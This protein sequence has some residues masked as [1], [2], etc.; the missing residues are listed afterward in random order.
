MRCKPLIYQHGIDMILDPQ[1]KAMREFTTPPRPEYFEVH[2]LNTNKT[3][4]S[5]QLGDANLNFPSTQFESEI[6]SLTL[7]DGRPGRAA[8]LR[9]RPDFNRDENVDPSIEQK[10]HVFRLIVARDTIDLQKT[11]MNLRWLL[12][13]VCDGATIISAVLMA[14]LIHRGLRS[15]GKLAARIADRRFDP[16]P[17]LQGRRSA[18]RADARCPAA[19]RSIA[20][21]SGDARAR[22]GVFIRRRP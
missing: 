3:M 22:E 13:L 18:H 7:P 4:R 16:R 17:A 15:T 1:L 6:R 21:P 19:Q 14:I 5:Q 10:Q 2:D 8:S 20:T 11:L 9:F 12:L